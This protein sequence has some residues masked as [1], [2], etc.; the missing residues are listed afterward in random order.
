MNRMKLASALCVVA[1]SAGCNGKNNAV[2]DDQSRAAGVDEWPGS[3]RNQSSNG[4]G[5]GSEAVGT[6]GSTAAA[7][8]STT[9][10][11][12]TLA[13][14]ASTQRTAPAGAMDPQQFLQQAAIGGMAE[15]QL[16]QLATERAASAQ[17]KQFARMMVR[18]HTKSNTE[19]K[20]TA[21]AQNIQLPTQLDQK[22]QEI[23]T[24]LQGLRGAEFDREYMR[25]MVDSHTEMRGLLGNRTSTAT[26]TTGAT[27]TTAATGTTGATGASRAAAE[28]GTSAVQQWATKNLPAVE[29]HLM[30]AQQINDKLQTGSSGAGTSNRNTP[31]SERPATGTSN[32]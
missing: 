20:Q 28:V 3:S 9:G 15:V 11:Q 29:H 22:H 24:R 17:V 6:S 31:G 7:D 16:G 18:D 12:G 4:A 21:K 19:L 32:R 27:G 25:V 26:A 14:G 30:E 13:G 8:Q 2:G 10:G 5:T 1:L 23:V